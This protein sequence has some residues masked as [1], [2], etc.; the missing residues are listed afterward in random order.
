MTYVQGQR[1]IPTIESSQDGTTALIVASR[2]GHDAVVAVFIAASADVNHPNKEGWTPL[3][4]ASRSGCDTVARLLL[5]AAVNQCQESGATPLF[6]AS[7]NGHI[8]T[9]RVLLE[10][11]ADVTQAAHARVGLPAV[12]GVLL[13]TCSTQAQT[14]TKAPRSTLSNGEFH[15][16]C[17]V[18]GGQTPLT[19][20]AWHGHDDMVRFLL[21]ANAAV[22]AADEVYFMTITA[23]MW[24]RCTRK[25]IRPSTAPATKPT[26]V[27]HGCSLMPA[28]MPLAETTSAFS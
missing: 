28:R 8:T 13:A 22:N 17:I 20:A 26:I 24:L 19:Q 18:K 27:L 14:P 21:D 5:G 15:S 12:T 7:Y 6:L 16:F 1:R 9:V 4:F 10:A 3:T 25:G 2:Y 11:G 23:L